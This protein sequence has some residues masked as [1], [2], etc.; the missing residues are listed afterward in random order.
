M[1]RSET[2]TGTRARSAGRRP[3]LVETF[4]VPPATPL[5]WAADAIRLIGAVSL[6]VGV[7]GWGALQGAVLALMF[8]GL[9]VPR[10]LGVRASID[11]AV[12]IILLVAAWSSVLDLYRSVAWI[13][14]PIHLA[15]NG[16]LALLVVVAADRAGVVFDHR[17]APLVALTLAVG[18]A[19][20]ALWEMGEWGGHQFDEAV[21]VGYDDSILD[22]A[23]GGLGAALVAF[24]VPAAL[25]EG[26]W[27]GGR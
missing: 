25:R 10:F 17:P 8:L 7:V 1:T 23:V 2:T 14:I 18:L 5:E 6:I 20:A 16:L 21:L 13:D 19:L 27:Q 22:M 9:V 26:R 4:L 3:A 15:L 24:L 11:V 12:G